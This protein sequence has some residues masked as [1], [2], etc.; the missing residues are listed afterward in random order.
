MLQPV[1]RMR[2]DTHFS[3]AHLVIIQSS[4]MPPFSLRSTLRDEANF[5]CCE[6]NF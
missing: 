5:P 3:G 1:R 6:G 2:N 4:M